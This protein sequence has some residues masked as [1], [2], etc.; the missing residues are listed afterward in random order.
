VRRDPE[1]L[2]EVIAR[3][4]EI[5]AAVVAADELERTGARAVLNYGHT[6]AHALETGTGHALMH[7]EAVGIGGGLGIPRSY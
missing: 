1:V 6:L 2:T 3:C 4:V 7:G 5:K